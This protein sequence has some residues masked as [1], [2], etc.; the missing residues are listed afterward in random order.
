[1]ARVHWK[2]GSAGPHISNAL[3]SAALFAL[4]T[5]RV[6]FYESRSFSKGIDAAVLERA[7]AGLL[8]PLLRLDGR[9]GFFAQDDVEY[10]LTMA[11]LADE[12][13]PTVEQQAVEMGCST[14]ATFITMA[15]Y[16]TRV[17]LNHLRI[18]RRAFMKMDPDQRQA[19][20]THPAALLAAYS[21]FTDAK[22]RGKKRKCPFLNFRQDESSASSTESESPHEEDDSAG[23]VKTVLKYFDGSRKKAMRL[24]SNGTQE[25]ATE[26]VP[27][28]DGLIVARWT[29]PCEEFS[30]DLPNA[31]L[32]ATQIVK[33]AA[34]TETTEGKQIL[35][36]GK[37]ILKKPAADAKPVHPVAVAAM[38]AAMERPARAK[39]AKSQS[40]FDDFDAAFTRHEQLVQ[41]GDE[42]NHSEANFSA[43]YEPRK[44]PKASW[45]R[46]RHGV[47]A[48]LSH[49]N[50]K[51]CKTFTFVF[52]KGATDAEFKE[53]CKKAVDSAIAWSREVKSGD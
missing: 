52:E 19:S 9:G 38:K 42:L 3:C 31:C 1:M 33:A 24:L 53:V 50:K 22:D 30:L 25:E 2:A 23:E 43:R 7:S 14:T 34:E 39:D 37:Q 48:R 10:G 18:K 21:L 26:L 13:K 28:E 12:L 36:K 15:A 44:Q 35:K 32:D 46:C 45:F 41:L 16:V 51:Y 17:M 27:G 4:L 6:F 40:G 20:K 11:F 29:S 5:S 49:G 8:Q 47:Q